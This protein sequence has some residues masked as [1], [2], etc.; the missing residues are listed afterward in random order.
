MQLNQEI[1]SVSNP[2]GDSDL[3]EAPPIYGAGEHHIA[4]LGREV[5]V[6]VVR[7]LQAGAPVIHLLALRRAGRHLALSLSLC[8]FF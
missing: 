2:H 1:R 5:K 7:V 3:P 8:S 6:R 4:L